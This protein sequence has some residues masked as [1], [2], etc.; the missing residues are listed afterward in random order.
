MTVKPLSHQGSGVLS[1]MSQA[2]CYIV[3]SQ[4]HAGCDAGDMVNIQLFDGIISH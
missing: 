3:L 2:N 4:E 1:S